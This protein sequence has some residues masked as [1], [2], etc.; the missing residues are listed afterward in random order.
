MT[1]QQFTTEE[2]SN[3]IWKDVVGYEGVYSVSNLGRVRREV[4]YQCKKQRILK[5]GTDKSGYLRVVLCA[6]RIKRTAPIHKLVTEA[7]IGKCDKGMEVNH[8]DPK[9]GKTN[10]RI[11][12]LE[13]LT[14]LENVHHAHKA[15]LVNQVR[16]EKVGASKLKEADIPRIFE[17]R[18]NG[19]LMR[20]ISVIVGVDK[21][22]IGKILSGKYW[23]FNRSQSA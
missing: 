18:R 1:E 7:F 14:H 2:L 23:N 15:G 12:N 6:K 22:H 5:P 20:E 8:I 10:N 13:Y 16:G 9:T 17:L 21:S 3:E 11:E 4:G 19:L